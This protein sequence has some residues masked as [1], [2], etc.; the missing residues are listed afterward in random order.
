MITKIFVTRLFSRFDIFYYIFEVCK[1][2]Y[3]IDNEKPS[4]L[5]YKRKSFYNGHVQ[6][7]MEIFKSPENLTCM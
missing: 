5:L 2:N 1:K 4:K 3:F 7:T 6:K